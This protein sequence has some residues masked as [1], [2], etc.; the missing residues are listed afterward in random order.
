MK[1]WE[2][3]PIEQKELQKKLIITEKDCLIEF[4]RK[5]S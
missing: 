3:K 1:P 5:I 4:Y 2:L